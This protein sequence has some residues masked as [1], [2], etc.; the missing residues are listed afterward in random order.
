MGIAYVF[1]R[2]ETQFAKRF[3][4]EIQASGDDDRHVRFR[5]VAARRVKENNLRKFSAQYH[6][7]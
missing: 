1:A 7:F 6:A 4:G 3:T 5:V 2:E